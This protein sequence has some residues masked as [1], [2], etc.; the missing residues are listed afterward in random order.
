M[1]KTKLLNSLV[2]DVEQRNCTTDWEKPNLCPPCH[3][4]LDKGKSTPCLILVLASS[5]SQQQKYVHSKSCQWRRK[6]QHRE[7]DNWNLYM[8]DLLYIL[9]TN[10]VDYNFP[11]LQSSVW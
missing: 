2:E 7:T 4:K 8:W 9:R 3:K 1:R 10:N 5:Q 11:T 6:S